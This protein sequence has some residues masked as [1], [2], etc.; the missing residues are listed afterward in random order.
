M[1]GGTMS[2][3]THRHR[4]LSLI[5][6][7]VLE[8]LGGISESTLWRWVHEDMVPPP[9]PGHRVWDRVAID[10]KLDR[11]NGLALRQSDF[12][13]RRRDARAQRAK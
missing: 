10:A 9:M 8:Y 6:P 2:S 11:R 5:P 3:W 4:V 1:G 12:D 7:E 13:E